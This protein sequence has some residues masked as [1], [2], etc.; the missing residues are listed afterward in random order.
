MHSRFQSRNL[1]QSLKRTQRRRMSPCLSP[2]LNPPLLPVGGGIPAAT[3]RLAAARERRSPPKSKFSTPPGRIVATIRS[4]P[5]LEDHH[6]RPMDFGSYPPR[7]SR[8]FS[9]SGHSK[10]HPSR[11]SLLSQSHPRTTGMDR[12]GFFMACHRTGSSLRS[13]Q[14]ISNI[15]QRGCRAQKESSLFQHAIIKPSSGQNAPQ[16]DFDSGH[17]EVV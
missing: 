9:S 15:S 3:G 7:S 4:D 2:L 11:A 12:F 17:Q 8:F 5:S 16:D 1:K 13:R 6:S 14:S 10:V